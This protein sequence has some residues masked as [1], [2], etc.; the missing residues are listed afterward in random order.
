MSPAAS[1]TTY[2]VKLKDRRQVAEPPWPFSLRSGRR[3]VHGWSVHGYDTHESVE[4][5]RGKEWT[6]IFHCECP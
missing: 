5:G 6:H 2:L 1:Q 3:H 4:N